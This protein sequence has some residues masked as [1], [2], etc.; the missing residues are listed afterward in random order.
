M[1]NENKKIL[2]GFDESNH[3]RDP[4]FFSLVSSPYLTD[5]EIVCTKLRE[6]KLLSYFFPYTERDMR[7]C[8]LS[9]ED[10][11]RFE[12]QKPIVH[13]LPFLLS[14]FSIEMEEIDLYIDGSLRDQE[15]R[16]ISENIV[17]QIRLKRLEIICVPK[18]KNKARTTNVIAL[19][20]GVANYLFRQG[21]SN[22]G[23]LPSFLSE[24]ELIFN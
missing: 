21:K 10:C 4:E 6:P 17:S 1:S 9:R 15:V 2:F 12:T 24:R 14:K 20:D 8:V 22:R 11:K 16:S 19:A 5:A 7:Y 23:I 18:P 3:G 13:V